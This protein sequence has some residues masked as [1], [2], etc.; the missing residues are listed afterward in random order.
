MRPEHASAFCKDLWEATEAIP[1]FDGY[2]LSAAGLGSRRGGNIGSGKGPRGAKTGR[3]EKMVVLMVGGLL[4]GLLSGLEM[5]SEIND[6]LE[7]LYYESLR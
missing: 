3:G 1:I 7:E 2:S 6:F 4:D 5:Q